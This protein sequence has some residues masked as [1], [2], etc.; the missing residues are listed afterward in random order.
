MYLTI[1]FSEE[2]AYTIVTQTDGARLFPAG[3][4]A[5]NQEIEYMSYKISNK[6]QG[7]LEYAMIMMLIALIVLVVVALLGPAIGNMYST[8]V[9]RI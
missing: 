8:V 9:P 3:N 5:T 1:D 7:L 4:L 2:T 6:G